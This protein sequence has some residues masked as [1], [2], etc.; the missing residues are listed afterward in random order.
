MY[1]VSFKTVK[2]L[3]ILKIGKLKKKFIS[4][5]NNFKIISVLQ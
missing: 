1:Y 5:G 3:K 4:I 2:K